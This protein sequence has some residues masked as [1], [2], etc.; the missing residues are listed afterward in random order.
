MMTIVK[1]AGKGV[2]I[3]IA[4]ENRVEFE[5]NTSFFLQLFHCPFVLRGAEKSEQ[6]SILVLVGK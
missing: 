2:R 3:L 5:G 6:Q 4:K 1:V